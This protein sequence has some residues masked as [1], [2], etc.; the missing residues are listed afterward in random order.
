MKNSYHYSLKKKKQFNIYLFTACIFLTVL[1]MGFS[2][3]YL[4]KDLHVKGV[5]TIKPGYP[6]LDLD[7]NID[8]E[9][10]VRVDGTYLK[11]WESKVYKKD[12]L[13]SFIEMGPDGGISQDIVLS[14]HYRNLM[15]RDLNNGR[16]EAKV[17]R[18]N[19]DAIT[20]RYAP[21]ITASVQGTYPDMVTNPVG[22][23]LA[24]LPI[25]PKLVKTDTVVR[26]DIIYDVDPTRKGK[27]N[28]KA[29]TSKAFS[30]YVVIT[31]PG[32]PKYEE[33]KAYI[34]ASKRKANKIMK[35]L[36][37]DSEQDLIPDSSHDIIENNV[38]LNNTASSNTV[39]NNATNSVTENKPANK[40]DNSASN[41]NTIKNE[42][43]AP[44]NK[45][46][47]K[48]D[49]KVDNKVEN[50]VETKAENN[51]VLP[52]QSLKAPSNVKEEVKK[53]VK[54]SNPKKVENLIT[55]N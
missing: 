33:Y 6:P 38:V 50:K 9:V 40:V 32:F 30:Y 16:V 28:G 12:T 46:E 25:D 14:F 55:S 18:G 13:I 34:E 27:K 42:V 43:V 54:E 44:T 23:F 2:L 4:K 7:V 20:F 41:T 49:N 45:V 26:Y 3:A 22:T 19:K 35:T 48:V 51:S 11:Y 29:A 47:N 15:P 17:T 52:Q 31:K 53:D 37:Q 36:I 8:T 10:T 1:C 21:S 24:Y 39:T 5:A